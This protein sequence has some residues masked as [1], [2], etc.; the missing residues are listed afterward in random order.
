ME[1][2][3]K[4]FTDATGITTVL[5]TVDHN[6]FQDQLTNYLG[7]TPDTA[8]TWFSGFRLKFFADQGF[9][10]PIDDVW[11]KVKGNFTDGFAQS[12]VGQRRQG[13]RHPRRLLPVGGLLPQETSSPTRAT[14]SR[15][16][17][18]SSSTL[19]HEDA[20]RRPDPDRLRRQGRLAGAWA[21][22]TSSTCA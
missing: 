15:R 14:P 9:N 12:V 6:T 1:A 21:R 13:L 3:N 11:A 22:S 20:D 8:Y 16:R 4:A 18:T 17:G 7:A 19:C 2:I 10:V 5:N